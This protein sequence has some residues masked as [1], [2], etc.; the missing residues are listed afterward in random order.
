VEGAGPARVHDSNTVVA[1]NGGSVGPHGVPGHGQG[2]G[3]NAIQTGE[4][5][6]RSLPS[7]P[8]PQGT[9]QSA[10]RGDRIPPHKERK[11]GE[12]E[13][14]S[15]HS[16]CTRTALVLQLSLLSLLSLLLTCCCAVVACSCIV[17]GCDGY[18]TR[19]A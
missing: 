5:S 19:A 10:A 6:E 15:A 3:S 16:H 7:A 14:V 18:A 4:G 9:K 2:V 1:G 11:E 17:V 13:E 12:R 8:H